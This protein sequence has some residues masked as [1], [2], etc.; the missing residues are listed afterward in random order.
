MFLCEDVTVRHK[1]CLMD[2]VTGETYIQLANGRLV[3]FTQEREEQA[4]RDG[5]E[6]PGEPDEVPDWFCKQWPPKPSEPAA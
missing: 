1:R 6:L 5:I 3:N 4:R 2:P